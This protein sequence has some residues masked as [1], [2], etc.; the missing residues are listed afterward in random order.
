MNK[1]DIDILMSYL[2]DELDEAQKQELESRLAQ[3]AALSA[4]LMQLRQARG[5][6]QTAAGE[7]ER[8]PPLIISPP[9][10]P[11]LAQQ[12][13]GSRGLRVA[14]ALALL[15]FA[16]RMSGLQ[17]AIHDKQLVVGFAAPVAQPEPDTSWQEELLASQD[18]LEGTLC[19]LEERM[20]RMREHQPEAARLD[21]KQLAAIR[22]ALLAETKQSFLS[23]FQ[24]AEQKQADQ[25]MALLD[26]YSFHIQQ[27]R[28]EDLELIEYTL[29]ELIQQ[30]SFQQVETDFLRTEISHIFNL[31]P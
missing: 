11:S 24:Q 20:Q 30:A 3:D 16:G 31:S 7:A 12:W 28:E 21:P 27:Q 14:A 13:L 22:Y 1:Q 15:L 5:C 4:E 6:L 9:A 10:Q 25:L 26:Q 8:L 2:Y 29:N 19:V 18:E 23:F 17:M